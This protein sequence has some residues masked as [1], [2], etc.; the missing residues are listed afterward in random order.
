ML[1]LCSVFSASLPIQLIVAP[2]S[3]NPRISSPFMWTVTWGLTSSLSINSAILAFLSCHLDV[4]TIFQCS[5]GNRCFLSSNRVNS[6]IRGIACLVMLS[7]GM[8]GGFGLM[9]FTSGLGPAARTGCC[10]ALVDSL[11]VSIAAGR[12]GSNALHPLASRSCASFPHT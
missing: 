6:A 12:V 3:N 1:H 4:L 9:W 5:F 7:S 8:S 10:S 11:F 2:L